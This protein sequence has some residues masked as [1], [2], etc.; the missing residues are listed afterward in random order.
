MRLLLWAILLLVPAGIEA[1]NTTVQPQALERAREYVAA[2]KSAEAVGMLSAYTPT[3]RELPLYHYTYAKALDLA[4][5][6][7]SSIE[8][9]RLAYLYAP[10]SEMKE[11]ALLDMAEA[12][13]RMKYD[14]EAATNFMLFLKNFPDSPFRE[15]AHFG[16]AESLYGSGLF[17]EALGHYEKSGDTCQARFGKANALQSMGKIDEAH[18]LYVSLIGKSRECSILSNETRY[19][20]GENFR[21]LGRLQDAKAYLTALKV[22][23]F[24][25]RADLSLG[26]IAVEE[27]RFDYAIGFFN[28]ALQS[29]DRVLRRKVLLS[30]AD[31]LVKTGKEEDA[32]ARLFEIKQK[33]PYGKDYDT[34][35]LMLATLYRRDGKLSEAVALLKELVIR[36]S[37]DQ[38]ALDECEAL[39]LGVKE[40]DAE[41][42]L[43]LWHAVGQW[44]MEPARAESLMKMAGLLRNSGKE[45]I[46][47]CLWLQ[48]HGSKNIKAQATLLLADYYADLGETAA[49]ER[50]IGSLRVKDTNDGILRVR[51]KI[52]YQG[53]D[54]QRALD[55][56]VA[57]KELRQEDLL[58]LPGMMRSSKNMKK[59]LDFYER[60]LAKVGGPPKAYIA[61]ADSLYEMGRRAD[62]LKYYR[63]A[64]AKQTGEKG[65]PAD[66][67]AWAFYRISLLTQGKESLEALG[68]IQVGNDI[69]GR[70]AAANAR[71]AHLTEKAGGGF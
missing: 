19:N 43:K 52:Y 24:K 32:R 22:P 39:L 63:E 30:L 34:A 5:K 71:E 21:L 14:S 44:L 42:F 37:P 46:S 2:K 31:L 66:D 68:N 67:A 6:T 13:Q 65:V 45:F 7:Y 8:H 57:I 56:L 61:F 40:K 20:I 23:P 50:S 17:N 11:L 29:Q 25:Y 51:A 70:V 62:S 12:Y 59:T 28:S 54:Y 27:A 48:R 26:L 41:G 16:L 53:G 47:L 49:A 69:F 55:S 58:L 1:G 15:R 4:K 60:A 18:D 64:V 35:L 9:L 36:R 33:Y 3:A 38:R 10:R